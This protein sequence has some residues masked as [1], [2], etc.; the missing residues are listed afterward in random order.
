[1]CVLRAPW[2]GASLRR[3]L[4]LL[5]AVSLFHTVPWV[6]LNA[7]FER[8]FER[9]KTLPLGLGRTEAT[10]GS[11]YLEHGNEAE[12][13]R[14]FRRSL[15]ANPRNNLAAYQL[16][17][18]AMRHHDYEFAIQ[19]FASALD[20]RPGTERY[21]LALADALLRS[22]RLEA[23]A[24]HLDTLAHEDGREPVYWEGLALARLGLGDEP[25]AAASLREARALAPGDAGL[26]SIVTR[27]GDRE[28]VIRALQRKWAETVEY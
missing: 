10:V 28:A 26:D 22:G 12:A 21:R 2:E 20:V 6:A 8:S 9:F 3:W 1:M 17:V 18:I 19:A 15:D 11:W 16:G 5:A 14:W 4:F 7:S 13:V 24:A 23:A 27:G 25:G